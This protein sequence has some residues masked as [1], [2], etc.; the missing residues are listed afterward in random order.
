MLDDRDLSYGNIL[1]KV[2]RYKIVEA[3]RESNNKVIIVESGLLGLA[4]NTDTKNAKLGSCRVG[5]DHNLPNLANFKNKNSPPDRWEKLVSNQGLEMKPW[6]AEGDNI[7]ICLQRKGSFAVRDI[8]QIQWLKDTIKEIRKYTNRKIVVR[9]KNSGIIPGI[10]GIKFSGQ[11]SYLYNA[12]AA[13]V[14]SSTID[15]K[16]VLNGVPTF[17]MTNRA[18]TYSMGNQSL[19]DIEQPVF[20]NREQFFYDLA[21]AQWTIEEIREGA[22][23]AHIKDEN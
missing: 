16:L 17:T 11:D 3:Q 1:K 8:D 22:A 21:Y 13:V 23:W 4:Y 2:S 18:F 7:I 9:T 5:L 15:I 19:S 10:E 6:R 20:A 12:W 14:M